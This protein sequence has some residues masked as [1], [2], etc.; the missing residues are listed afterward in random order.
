MVRVNSVCP[1]A[2]DTPL[3]REPIERA[4]DPEAAMRSVVGRYPL[5]R[6]ASAEEIAG[7]VLFLASQQASYITGI[8][9]AVDG[10]RTLH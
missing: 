3:L 6:I 9:M 5:R 8:S 7:A 4:A 2:V 1:G 10:G